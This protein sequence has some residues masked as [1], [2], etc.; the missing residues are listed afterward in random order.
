MLAFYLNKDNFI[1]NNFWNDKRTR[2]SGEKVV[3]RFKRILGSLKKDVNFTYPI[4][5][6]DLRRQ[7]I[8]D[9][10]FFSSL[11]LKFLVFS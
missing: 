8:S 9:T 3:H 2:N 7:S 1:E 5:F 11:S 6:L 4:F 10:I